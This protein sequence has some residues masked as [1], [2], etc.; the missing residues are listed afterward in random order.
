MYVRLGIVGPGPAAEAPVDP[1]AV[2]I[3]EIGACRV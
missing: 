3:P 2:E 1:R